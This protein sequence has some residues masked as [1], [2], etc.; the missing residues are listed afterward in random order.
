MMKE[1][2]EP[3][4]KETGESSLLPP[5]GIGMAVAFDWGLAVQIFATPLFSLFLNSSTPMK[6]AGFNSPVST[7]LFFL[8]AWLIAGGL[9]VF[10]EMIRR[11]RNWARLIQVVVNGLLSL[12]GLFSL[13]RLYQSAQV[14]NFWPVV[15]EVILLVFSPL[16]VW[17]LSRPVTARWFHSVAVA[18]AMKRHGGKWIWFIALWAIAGGLLQTIAAM[19]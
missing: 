9:I 4:E 5:Q 13:L 2:Q 15:T 19:Q 14:G 12:G 11:G 18:D 6:M 16:I 3:V 1:T 8:I 7:V 10:G 17:R